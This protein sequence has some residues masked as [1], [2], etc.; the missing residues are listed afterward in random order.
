MNEL[1]HDLLDDDKNDDKVRLEVLP[2][3]FPPRNAAAPD[4]RPLKTFSRGELDDATAGWAN[5]LGS[6]GY[7]DVFLGTI[8]GIE[9]AV[10]RARIAQG[11]KGQMR[12]SKI[13]Q[14]EIHT[15]GRISHE[16]ITKL[17]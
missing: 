17:I 7:G 11:A 5:P 8:D 1:V 16:N 9:V 12:A 15:M 14:A 4:R 3:I 6:G 13:L 2:P 10:K